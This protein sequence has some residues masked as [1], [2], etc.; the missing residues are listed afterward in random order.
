M[1]DL[2]Q[3]LTALAWG[4]PAVLQDPAAAMSKLGVD[5]PNGMR[6]DV[7][8][9]RRDTLYLVIP[10]ASPDGEPGGVVNQMDLWRSGDQFVWILSQDAK[11]A[12]LGMREQFRGRTGQDEQ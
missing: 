8:V 10:P 12:L 11:L 4:D 5:V 6:L 1:T 7:R 9:Q 3:A 2:E